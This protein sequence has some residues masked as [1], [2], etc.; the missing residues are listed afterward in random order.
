MTQKIQGGSGSETARDS[1]LTNANDWADYYSGLDFA[2]L[3]RATKQP[4]RIDKW[5]KEK[6]GKIFE[7]GCGGS[8]LLARSAC[9]GWEVS[10]IDFN[11][12]A[13]AHL[14][15]FLKSKEYRHSHL[16]NADIFKYD[17]G[18]LSETYD[19]LVS[20]GFLEHFNNPTQILKKW[21][22]IVRPGG[23]VISIIPNLYSFNA[24]IFKK[25][26]PDFWN[27]HVVFSPENFESFHISIGLTPLRSADYMGKYNI[28]MLIPWEK[29]ENKIQNKW[30]FKIIKYAANFGIGSVLRLLPDHGM[31]SI[32][33]LIMGVYIKK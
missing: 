28:H 5:L 6:T 15:S 8:S 10:G 25:F 24:G 32:N 4:C 20:F 19:I 12:A 16:I 22:K 23:L 11:Q 21:T 33:P 26:D 17:C 2:R 31:R 27:M 13:L 30:I 29:I 18:H 9:L 1:A 7:L 3:E 14:Q